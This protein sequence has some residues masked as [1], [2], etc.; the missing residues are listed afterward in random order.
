MGQWV[1]KACGS[2]YMLKR[3]LVC[4]T[5]KGMTPSDEL[6]WEIVLFNEYLCGE[7][8]QFCNF[9]QLQ[10]ITRPDQ[11]TWQETSYLFDEV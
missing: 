1:K 2:I 7:S 6:E 11:T 3:Y 4:Q 10:A 9:L 8:L 5:Y